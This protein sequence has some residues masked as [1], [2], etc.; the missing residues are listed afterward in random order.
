[1]ALSLFLGD[2]SIPYPALCT[3][4]E[5]KRDSA[6]DYLLALTETL[7]WAKSA[8]ERLSAAGE[9]NDVLAQATDF[10]LALKLAKSDYECAARQVEAYRT[11]QNKAIKGSAEATALVFAMLVMHTERVTAHFRDLLDGKYDEQGLGSRAEQQAE[12]EAQGDDVWKTLPMSAVMATY[13]IVQADAKTG[14]LGR[15]TLTSSQR[16]EVL[17]RL[18]STFGPSIT[19]GMKPGQLALEA[20]AGALYGFL[21]DE[22]WKSA[23]AE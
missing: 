21:S 1:M 23:D 13:S 4:T 22:Q 19:S 16:S 15:L 11:S 2:P 6:Y 12:L 3:P 20:T 14:K 5:A 18:R 8:R 7:G 17:K 10:M 9:G